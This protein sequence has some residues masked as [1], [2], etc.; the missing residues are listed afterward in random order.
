MDYA[1]ETYGLIGRRGVT[2]HRPLSSNTVTYQSSD[3]FSKPQLSFRENG[4][5][6]FQLQKSGVI[7]PHT[8]KWLYWLF[9][10][11]KNGE[12]FP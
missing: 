11:L 3:L 9:V 12:T 7:V 6:I 5:T 8:C 2:K 4:E 1:G 10:F